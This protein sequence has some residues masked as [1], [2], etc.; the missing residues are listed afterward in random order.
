LQIKAQERGDLPFIA[1]DGSNLDYGN[2][3]KVIAWLKAND[4]QAFIE[5]AAQNE[6]EVTLTVT[7]C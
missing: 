2:T 7:V 3:Q 1:F 4:L 6:D 5:K